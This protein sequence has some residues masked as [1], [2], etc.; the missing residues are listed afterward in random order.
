MTSEEKSNPVL[1]VDDEEDIREVLGITLSDMG[2]D[3]QT[4]ENGE[5]ALEMFHRFGFP[6]VLTDIKMPGMDGIALLKRIKTESPYTEIIMITGHGDMNLAINSFRNEAVEFITKPVDV[7]SLKVAMDRAEEKIKLRQRLSDYTENLEK[8]VSEKSEAL[9]KVGASEPESREEKTDIRSVMDNLP[10]VIFFVNRDLEITASNRL[11]KNKFGE[12][13]DYCYAA[14]MMR[15]TP[16]DK[17]PALNCF[18]SQ[19][20]DQLEV[21]FKAGKEK[22][23]SY[24]A[25][26]SPVADAAGEVTDAMIIAT[27]INQIVDI[28]NHLTSLGLMVGSISHGIKGLLTGLDGGVYVLDSALSKQDEDQAKEGLEMVK[29]MTHKI[30]KLILDILFFAKDRDLKKERLTAKQFV[31]DLVNVIKPRAEKNGIQVK[32]LVADETIEFSGDAGVLHSAFLNILENAV[33]ACINDTKETDHQIT[34]SCTEK[35][36]AV[37]FVISDNGIGMEESEVEN[38]FTLF[39]SSKGTGGTGLGLFITD[40]S[41][42]QHNGKISVNSEKSKGT[43]FVITLPLDGNSGN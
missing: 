6:I 24:L 3:V 12:I 40:K 5:K 29:Q 33:D 7:E 20:S 17:C 21:T 28:Q 1:L 11:F 18:T 32:S 15:E 8:L 16:C 36:G 10:L 35:E 19:T 27:D 42:K 22:E 39:H 9:K 4:A 26:S 34:L 41:V 13:H 38:A 23:K 37:E 14:L 43:D 31:D 25:W 2:Y 30:R